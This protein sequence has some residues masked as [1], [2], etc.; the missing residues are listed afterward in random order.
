MSVELE[1][2][3]ECLDE[4]NYHD[5]YCPLIKLKIKER[6]D[7]LENK[8]NKVYVIREVSDDTPELVFYS[9]KKAENW[10]ESFGK[11]TNYKFIISKVE[12]YDE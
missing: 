3:E 1:L 10:V 2:L 7:L 8:R 6:I 9:K 4:L 11:E 5:I 12:V